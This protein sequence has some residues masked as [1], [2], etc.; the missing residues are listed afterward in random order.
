MP[1]PQPPPPV[2]VIGYEVVR[3]SD[4]LQGRIRKAR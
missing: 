1:L 4:V 3:R 2:L